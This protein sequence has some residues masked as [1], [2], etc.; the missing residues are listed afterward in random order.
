M[1]VV[2]AV[3]AVPAVAAVASVV[4]VVRVFVSVVVDGVV[5]GDIVGVEEELVVVGINDDF[6]FTFPPKSWVDAVRV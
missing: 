6:D 5:V 4:V 3:A 1:A 2:A